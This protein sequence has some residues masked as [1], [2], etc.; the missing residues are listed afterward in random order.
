MYEG[1]LKELSYTGMNQDYIV[2]M[3]L[4]AKP[5]SFVHKFENSSHCLGQY[6]IKASNISLAR[7]YAD[8]ISDNVKIILE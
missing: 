1:K 4:F 6:T 5:G 8:A 3:Q 2:D 7:Q